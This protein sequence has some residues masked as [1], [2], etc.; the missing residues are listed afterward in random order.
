MFYKHLSPTYG[1]R[2]SKGGLSGVIDLKVSSSDSY[3]LKALR[4]LDIAV[5]APL[6]KD[7]EG[8]NAVLP[9]R[10]PKEVS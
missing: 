7:P 10:K 8:G 6:R 4:S 5:V 9:S 1:V 3:A 2:V